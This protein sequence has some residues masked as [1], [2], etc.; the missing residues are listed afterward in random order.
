MRTAADPSLGRTPASARARLAGVAL[1]AA[2]AAAGP[3]QAGCDRH[4]QACADGDLVA[5]LLGWASRLSGL[6]PAPAGQAPSWAARPQAELARVVCG[7]RAADCR[8]LVA[9]YDTERRHIVYDAALDLR[10]PTDQSYL[11]HE[12][13][14]YLQHLS[15]GER[16]HES[17]EAVVASE[18]AAYAVQNRYL[19]RFKQWRR[20]GEAMRYA[21]CPADHT[22]VEPQVHYQGA[23]R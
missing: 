22:A 15:L 5:D 20:V 23:L 13:V 16:L 9:A 8:G 17:C 12:L 21:A 14:H 7:E 4:P 2:L 11:L 1:A 3:A 10:D 19:E 18:R 6:P